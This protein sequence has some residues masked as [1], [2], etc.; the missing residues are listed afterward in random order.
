MLVRQGILDK[1][2]KGETLKRYVTPPSAS[3]TVSGL[4]KLNNAVNSSD[5][6][7]AATSKAVKS[8]YDLAGKALMKDS[9]LA[10][11]TNVADALTNLG[12]GDAA[13]RSGITALNSQN[14]WLSIPVA[15]GSFRQ[16]III[17]WGSVSISSRGT[18]PGVDGWIQSSVSMGFPIA[19]PSICCS[20]TCSLQHGGTSTQWVAIPNLS[21]SSRLGGICR[22]QTQY[23]M[24]LIPS[25][26][27]IAIGY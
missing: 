2:L 4:T 5:E 17:Q 12:L 19:F 27:W 9:N 20:A 24:E 13:S 23:Q 6:D 1:S 18:T 16:T 21:I 3:L 15:I 11:L 14:G 25:V 10:D 8:A 26:S 7:V 22:L